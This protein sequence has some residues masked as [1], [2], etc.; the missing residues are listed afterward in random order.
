MGRWLTQGGRAARVVLEATGVYSWDIALALQRTARVEV[1]VLNPRVS[2][3][4]AGACGQR[5]STDATAA[6]RLR[7]YAARMPFVPWVPPSAA[8]TRTDPGSGLLSSRPASILRDG[9]SGR[10]RASQKLRART[11]GDLAVGA[12]SGPPD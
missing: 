8:V 9:E 12:G 5:A 6:R 10:E 7:E 2:K 1:M 3:D 11:G 4:F